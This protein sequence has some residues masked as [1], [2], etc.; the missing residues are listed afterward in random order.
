[1]DNK[2]QV[3]AKT[4]LVAYKYLSTLCGAI[5]KL[6]DATA[7]N[8]FYTCGSWSERNAIMT[9]SE[10]I[11]KL[12]DKKVNYINLKVMVE[13]ILG[14]MPKKYAKVLILKYIKGLE[15]NE[16]SELMNMSL[17]SYYR[18]LK[19]AIEC[20]ALAMKSLGFCVE[21]LEIRYLDDAFISSVR[22]SVVRETKFNGE[23]N[24][25]LEEE[26]SIDRYVS[27]LN[28]GNLIKVVI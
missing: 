23:E 20:F 28:R 24:S 4:F 5:D 10:R 6:I 7:S 11:I 9:V 26:I 17:R 22:E 27:M 19:S 15:K 21:K 18:R 3:W 12:S 13:K 14:V 8:S 2:Q 1:M 16:I 25:S